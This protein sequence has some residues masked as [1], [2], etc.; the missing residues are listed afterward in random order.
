MTPPLLRNKFRQLR[1]ALVRLPINL[2]NNRWWIVLGG[3]FFYYSKPASQ[4]WARANLVHNEISFS[5]EPRVFISLRA[6]LRR[7]ELTK[8]SNQAVFIPH[9]GR[10][11]NAIREVVP[12]IGVA[13]A[14]GIGHVFLEGD[15]VFGAQSDV[16]HPGIHTS[17]RGLKVW[18]D[19][20]LRA[21]K[22]EF[23]VLVSWSRGH[24]SINGAVAENAW[25]SARGALGLDFLDAPFSSR[26]LV[27]HL[28]GG[29]VFGDREVL[30]YGQP[31]L[32]FYRKI[33][34]SAP[35]ESLV[36]VHQDLRNPVLS[37]LTSFCETQNILCETHS[38]S[39]VDDLR[40]LLRARNFVAGRGTFSP[41]VAGL[42]QHLTRVY[43]FED[44]FTMSPPR[45]ALEL[46]RVVDTKG[47]YRETVL[48]GK[49]KNSA[50][51]LDLMVTYPS[52]NL[53]I[54]GAQP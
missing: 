8:L 9:L 51:Q 44:K 22:S 17:P 43:F 26:T 23:H 36:I 29:D 37:E 40:V 13:E 21:G 14:I 52:E 4:K 48:E 3:R 49:W 54:Q 15:N 50:E 35:W 28:R 11:G 53:D 30:N 5:Q 31:P 45:L 2:K 6:T 19:T 18:I 10:F 38:G 7:S 47:I 1:V 33:L 24:V 42:S 41:A 34:D 16:P 32:A 27:I 39:L 25:E 20:P 12:A 46:C